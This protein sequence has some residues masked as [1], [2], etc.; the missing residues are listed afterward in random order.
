MKMRVVMKMKYMNAIVRIAAVRIHLMKID[1]DDPNLVLQSLPQGESV[2]F[3]N[4][5]C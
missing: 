5:L 1:I 3:Q 4:I 2:D